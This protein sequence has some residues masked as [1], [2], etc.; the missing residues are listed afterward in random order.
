MFNFPLDFSVRNRAHDPEMTSYQMTT[1]LTLNVI[2]FPKS[3]IY[4]IFA[5]FGLCDNTW[6]V[7]N[8]E[9]TLWSSPEVIMTLEDPNGLL[10]F[11]TMNPL[12]GKQKFS[13]WLVFF[14]TQLGIFLSSPFRACY[15][16][17]A[18]GLSSLPCA[19]RWSAEIG[20][21]LI[22]HCLTLWLL[23]SDLLLCIL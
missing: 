21:S 23:I 19:H 5:I 13:T 16:I 6:L 11:L 8:L 20:T 1:E 2:D 17:A 12:E 7:S 4:I 18:G 3:C 14:Q 9:T 10:T 15:Y 22:W